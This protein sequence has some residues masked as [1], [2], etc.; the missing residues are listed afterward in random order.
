FVNENKYGLRNSLWSEDLSVLERAASTVTNCGVLNLN[1]SHSGFLP[2][3]P[4]HGGTGLT[5][6]AFGEANYLMLRTSRLQGVDFVRP[7]G[8]TSS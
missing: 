7:G 4:T 3:L 2:F 5:G 6:G 8:R 1:D